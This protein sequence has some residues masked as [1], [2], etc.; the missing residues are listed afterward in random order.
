[1][2]R[3]SG[4]T[5]AHDRLAADRE[6]LTAE[7]QAAA[8]RIHEDIWLERLRIET[9]RPRRPDTEAR[10]EAFAAIDPATLLAAVDHE[11]EFRVR[12]RAAL[13]EIAAKMPA[14]L[15]AEDD[16]AADLDALCAEAEAVILGRLSGRT[17]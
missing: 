4:Q 1:R 7:I 12:A 10:P 11:P 6:G 13:A 8:H 16:L 9:E 17:C 2:V 3:L 15:A 14:G 5:P